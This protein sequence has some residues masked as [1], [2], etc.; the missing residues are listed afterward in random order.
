MICT[1][2]VASLLKLRRRYG[3]GQDRGGIG[4]D[5][6]HVQPPVQLMD[7]DYYYYFI[8]II[9]LLLNKTIHEWNECSY[10]NII[11]SVHKK[12]L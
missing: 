5:K 2:Q 8:I 9:L 12:H 1:K 6:I 3:P 4:P 7:D 11:N 10:R